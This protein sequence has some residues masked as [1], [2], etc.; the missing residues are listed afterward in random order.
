[1]KN[2]LKHYS[3]IILLLLFADTPCFAEGKIEYDKIY[4]YAM[5]A[6]KGEEEGHKFVRGLG[7]EN[8]E[9]IDRSAIAIDL[10]DRHGTK[11]VIP[12]V[13][14]EDPYLFGKVEHYWYID[15]PL[16]KDKFSGGHLVHNQPEG[17]LHIS[18]VFL[19]FGGQKSPYEIQP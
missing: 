8:I 6:L 7:T 9:G 12:V 16:D 11:Y 14:L 1:M 4:Q 13:L 3:S 10:Y 18:F 19:A 2:K 15:I 17:A 5:L